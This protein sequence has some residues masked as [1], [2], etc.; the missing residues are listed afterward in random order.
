MIGAGG[1]GSHSNHGGLVGRNDGRGRISASYAWGR[2]TETHGSA[3]G[4]VGSQHGDSRVTA[5]YWDT[6]TSGQTRSAGGVGKTTCGVAN[7]HRL[8]RTSM[9][10]GTSTST[11]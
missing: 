10:T 5:S 9:P 6:A 1:S 7:A 4:L 2:V 8:Q 3:G 11:A